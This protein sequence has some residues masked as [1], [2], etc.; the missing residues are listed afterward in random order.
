M[1]KAKRTDNGR[2]RELTRE[3]ARRLF[4]RQARRTLKMSGK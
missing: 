4:D 1:A 2:I 3:E